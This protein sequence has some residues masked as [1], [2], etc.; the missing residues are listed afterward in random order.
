MTKKRTFTTSFG[1]QLADASTLF[2]RKTLVA[3]RPRENRTFS[4]SLY[5]RERDSR[6]G[7]HLRKASGRGETICAPKK[8]T[9]FELYVNVGM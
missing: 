2:Y 7:H 8:C 3:Y 1:A 9:S 4:L 6:K 5:R